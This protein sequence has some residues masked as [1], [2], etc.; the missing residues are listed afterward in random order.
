[1]ECPRFVGICTQHPSHATHSSTT[2]RSFNQGMAFVTFWYYADAIEALNAKVSIDG[3]R[4][5]KISIPRDN[6]KTPQKAMEDKIE[7]K[8]RQEFARQDTK[9][10]NSSQKGSSSRVTLFLNSYILLKCPYC[11]FSLLHHLDYSFRL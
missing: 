5:I 3:G 9:A 11:N 2:L 4:Y 7:K 1:M 6:K 10:R 8:P